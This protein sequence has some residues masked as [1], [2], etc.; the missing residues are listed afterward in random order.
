MRAWR[1]TSTISPVAPH[2]GRHAVTPKP[3]HSTGRSPASRADYDR[4]RA[5]KKNHNAA[6][7]F[8][9]RCDVLFAMLRDGTYYRSRPVA[10]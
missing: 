5:E 4:K 2:S 1:Y 7:I 9:A 6:L 8:I 10:A 3:R